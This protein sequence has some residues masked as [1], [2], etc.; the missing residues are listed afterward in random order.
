M[1]IA[2]LVVQFILYGWVEQNRKELAMWSSGRVTQVGRQ[3]SKLF[4]LKFVR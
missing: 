4:E 3:G 1:R 2:A